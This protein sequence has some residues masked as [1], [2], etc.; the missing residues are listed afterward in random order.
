MCKQNANK[1]PIKCKSIRVAAECHRK[2]APSKVFLVDDPQG[3]AMA[4]FG[5]AS[6]MAA[7]TLFWR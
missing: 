2:A 6:A 5:A 7:K 3:Q 1:T 4:R